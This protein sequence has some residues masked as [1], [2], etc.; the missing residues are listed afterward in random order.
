MMAFGLLTVSACLIAF[1]PPRPATWWAIA[2]GFLILAVVRAANVLDGSRPANSPPPLWLLVVAASASAVAIGLGLLGRGSAP[3]GMIDTLDAAMIAAATLLLVWVFVADVV[4]PSRAEFSGAMLI[5]VASTFAVLATMVKVTMSTGLRTLAVALLALAAAGFLASTADLLIMDISDP[6]AAGNRVP[7]MLWSVDGVLLGAA[8]VHS[9]S[10]HAVRPPRRTSTELPA[11]RI[12]LFAAIAVVVPV[13]LSLDLVHRS[14]TPDRGVAGITGPTVAAVTVL[15]L[16][17]GRLA[18]TARTSDRRSEALTRRTEALAQAINR[19]DTL[20]QELA[21]RA[22]HD[23]LT[24]LANRLVLAE[25]METRLARSDH[26]GRLCA[27]LLL[28]LDGFKDINDTRGHPTGDDLL[29][30]VAARLV[31]AAPPDTLVARLGGDEFAMLFDVT[32][33]AKATVRAEQIL[34]A[35]HPPFTISGQE[36]FVSASIGLLLTDTAQT[37]TTPSNALRDADLSLYAAKNA[38]KNRIVVFRP[39]L[40]ATRMEHAR[41]S[42][43]LHHALAR[44]EISVHYQT[45]VDLRSHSVFAVEALARWQPHTGAT[46][47]PAQFIPVAEATGMINMLGAH[48]LRSACTTAKRWYRSYGVAVS[49]NVSGQQLSDPNFADLV[50]S[51][52]NDTGMPPAGLILELT[53]SSLVRTSAQQPEFRQFTRLRDLG[54]RIA[55]DDFGTGYSSL[56]YIVDLP[57]DIV[58]LDRS[59]ARFRTG[60]TATEP[61]WPFTGAI[62]Q[63]IASLGLQAITEGVETAEQADEL[64]RLR[65]PYAQGFL[66]SLPTPAEEVDQLLASPS[67]NR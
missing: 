22:T 55:I 60:A 67:M 54:V 61:N 5:V 30:A 2:G 10:T 13:A 29:A 23:P 62:L 33:P 24:G 66:F 12:A 41:I 9:T 14:T 1:R 63:V 56:S 58:K 43:G 52:L 42:A 48:V 4:E 64:R 49:V 34:T 17:V 19:Q 11:L 45:I 25:Q 20:Q 65:C 21:H 6:A 59:F 47:P 27:L 32:T 50:I 16:L 35:L 37:P 38:G 15:L 18:M 44:D 39:E 28:D 8:A 51:I 57:V 3:V 46:I 36:L 31:T 26:S 53:E 7:K 40:R